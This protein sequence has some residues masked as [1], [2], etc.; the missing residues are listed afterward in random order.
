M[1]SAAITLQRESPIPGWASSN[2]RVTAARCREA[3]GKTA[4]RPLTQVVASD[5]SSDEVWRD[6]E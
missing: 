1:T 3:S 2:A 5:R 6:R 4:R